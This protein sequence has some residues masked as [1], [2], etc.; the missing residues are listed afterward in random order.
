MALAEV[1]T[2]RCRLS[3]HQLA[4]L[5]NRRR[6][7]DAVIVDIGAMVREYITVKTVMNLTVAA[8]QDTQDVSAPPLTFAAK[9]YL[10]VLLVAESG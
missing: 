2:D 3:D 5:E 9:S 6:A 10:S 4:V 8:A 1:A 7:V